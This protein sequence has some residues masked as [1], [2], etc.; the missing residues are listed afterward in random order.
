MNLIPEPQELTV[1]PDKQYTLPQEATLCM[2]GHDSRLVK[3]GAALFAGLT[4]Q[5][6]S[7]GTYALFCGC[8]PFCRPEA[9]SSEV[10]HLFLSA[11][12]LLSVQ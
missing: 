11:L 2:P 10:C 5:P 8:G 6:A 4:T 3:G 12:N 9:L 1:Q 7:E